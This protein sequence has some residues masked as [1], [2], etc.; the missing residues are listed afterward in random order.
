LGS[1]GFILDVKPFLAPALDGVG[2]LQIKI[3]DFWSGVDANTPYIVDG[4][5]QVVVAEIKDTFP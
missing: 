1:Q 3:P 5:L 4:V 2:K